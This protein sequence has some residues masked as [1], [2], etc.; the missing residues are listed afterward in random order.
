MIKCYPCSIG[1]GGATVLQNGR[2]G[3][4]R[5][6]KF[7]LRGRWGRKGFSPVEGGDKTYW[8]SFNM[9]T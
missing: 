4:G 9:G 5:Q 7:T 3:G 1:G 6:V 8:G 2:E